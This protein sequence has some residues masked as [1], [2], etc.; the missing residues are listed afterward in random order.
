MAHDDLG[1]GRTG[2]RE[3]E[4]PD[5][6]LPEVDQ[7]PARRRAPNRLWV[8]DF[9]ALNG[10]SDL[11]HESVAVDLGRPDLQRG[12]CRRAQSRVDGLPVI[13]RRKGRVGRRRRPLRPRPDHLLVAVGVS[14]D[15][16][17][18]DGHLVPIVGVRVLEPEVAAIP[19]LRQPQREPIVV[20]EQ[21]GD[22]DGLHLQAPFVGRP[23]RVQYRVGHPAPVQARLVD[24]VRSGVEHG[25][26]HV[27]PVT[28]Q[29][30]VRAQIDD[31]MPRCH[32]RDRHGLIQG[33]RDRGCG[34]PVLVGQSRPTRLRISR[35]PGTPPCRHRPRRPARTAGR[36]RCGG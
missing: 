28:R 12:R 1:P 20:G 29:R 16:R 6:V 18:E 19:A 15:K 5:Q 4:P 25:R 17:G 26:G 13:E 36:G 24:P 35:H 7:G 27:R 2:H 14:D 21:G 34:H 31:R 22:V 23:S 33:R 9:L 3:P 11:G 10:W 32:R 8:K 30:K